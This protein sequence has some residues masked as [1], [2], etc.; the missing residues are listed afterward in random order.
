VN[1]E[2]MD[3]GVGLEV[4]FVEVVF[5]GVGGVKVGGVGGVRVEVDLVL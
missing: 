2:V 3:V 4:A 1:E 5:V